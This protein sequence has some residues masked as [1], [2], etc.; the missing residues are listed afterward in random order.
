MKVCV[1]IL[2]LILLLLS[3]SSFADYY[4][5]PMQQSSWELK[6]SK[7]S[8]QL[9][10]MIPL[11][12]SADFVHR[13][14]ENLQF[15]IQEQR[16]KPQV[17]RATLAAMPAPWMRSRADSVVYQVYLDQPEDRNDYGR[18]SVYGEAA[19]AMI[20]ALLQ[21]RYPTF[22]YIRESSEYNPEET[23]VEVSSIKFSESYKAFS[24][25]RKNLLQASEPY[26]RLPIASAM[27]HRFSGAGNFDVA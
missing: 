14:G 20:D 3:A 10:Q 5:V 13:S 1:R 19:E 16:R 23:R 27:P 26:S 18:L 17:I 2:T 4:Q 9:K 6:R 12:G 15:S 21:G 24:E 7:N 22:T 25:C 11:Y 8:C